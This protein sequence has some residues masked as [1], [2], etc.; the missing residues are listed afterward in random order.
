[1]RAAAADK[2][3]NHVKITVRIGFPLFLLNP[4]AGGI[5][6]QA[7]GAGKLEVYLFFGFAGVR[8]VADT[9]DMAVVAQK[10]HKNLLCIL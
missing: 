8:V 7:F 10:F 9:V 2:M 6:L 1:M 3:K 4:K 5:D